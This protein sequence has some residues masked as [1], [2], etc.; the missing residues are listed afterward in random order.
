[1]KIKEHE[2]ISTSIFFNLVAISL[3]LIDGF[4]YLTAS[5]NLNTKK[6]RDYLQEGDR[7]YCITEV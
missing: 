4:T 6:C 3:K 1:M 5:F 7:K 2:A